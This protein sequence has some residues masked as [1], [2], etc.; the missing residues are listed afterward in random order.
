M[1]IMAVTHES[2]KV[3]LVSTCCLGVVNLHGRKELMFIETLCVSGTVLHSFPY[4]ISL[5]PR[6]T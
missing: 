2:Q 4:N 6:N 3:G 5:T 1:K